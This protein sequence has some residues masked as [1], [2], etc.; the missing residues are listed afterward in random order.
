MPNCRWLEQLCVARAVVS[1][2]HLAAATK[3]NNGD[4]SDVLRDFPRGVGDENIA[5]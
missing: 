5:N 2:S 4:S 1:R 3:L